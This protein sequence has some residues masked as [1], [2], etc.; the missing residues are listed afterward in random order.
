MGRTNV[1]L[2]DRLVKAGLKMTRCKTKKELLHLALKALVA[3]KSRKGLFD[4]EGRVTW[5]GDLS[6]MR[7]SHV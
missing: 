3:K 7:K 1:D 2:D 5:A 4:L 6:Q